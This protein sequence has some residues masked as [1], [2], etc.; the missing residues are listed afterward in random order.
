MGP[1]TLRAIDMPGSR[2]MDVRYI[3]LT[4]NLILIPMEYFNTTQ[5]VFNQDRG[6]INLLA[7]LIEDAIAFQSDIFRFFNKDTQ[8]PRKDSDTIIFNNNI[9][10]VLEGPLHLPGIYINCMALRVS[11]GILPKAVACRG[12]L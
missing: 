1:Y 3:V 12:M 4:R 11:N 2:A 8:L 7:L 10:G 9:F 5:L 6:I